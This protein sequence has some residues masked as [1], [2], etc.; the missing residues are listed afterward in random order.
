MSA[1]PPESGRVRCTCSCLLWANSGHGVRSFNHLVG[2]PYE[3]VGYSDAECFGSSEVYDQFD[4]CGLL[5]WQIA[6]LFALENPA[7]IDANRA[8]LVRNAGAIT[9]KTAG[10]CKF[11]ETKRRRQFVAH[12]QR[13]E[14]LDTGEKK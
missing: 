6:R 1:L 12:R 4:F 9:N 8:M 10:L 2:A 13:G 7:H 5:D 11:G 3:R 14:P